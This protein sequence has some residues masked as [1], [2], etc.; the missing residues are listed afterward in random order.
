MIFMQKFSVFIETQKAGGKNTNPHKVQTKAS[1]G[2]NKKGGIATPL[3][4]VF[5]SFLP[6]EMNQRLLEKMYINVQTRR[7]R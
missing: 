3:F 1:F 2:T 6:Q 7:V 5:G 4:V